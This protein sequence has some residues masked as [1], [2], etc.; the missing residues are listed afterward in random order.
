MLLVKKDLLIF[1]RT[2]TLQLVNAET[3]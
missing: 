3:T 2:R 1:S